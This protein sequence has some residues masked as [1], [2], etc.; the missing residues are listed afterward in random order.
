VS[1]EG[2]AERNLYE[3]WFLDG[4]MELGS[5]ESGPLSPM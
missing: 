5:L 1:A 4:G 3:T 2:H